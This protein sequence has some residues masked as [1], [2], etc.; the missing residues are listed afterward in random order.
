MH[1]WI[2]RITLGVFFI[3]I[4][5]LGIFIKPSQAKKFCDGQR[6][7]C[8]CAHLVAKQKSGA[9]K[10]ISAEHGTIAKES[11]SPGG[12]PNQFLAVSDSHLSRI[13]GSDYSQDQSGLYSFR[14]CRLIEH[15]PKV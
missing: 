7:I 5:P 6:A 4:L 2:A 11:S 14:L 3:W 1:K 12:S 13:I 15:I 8:L 10:M 9:G